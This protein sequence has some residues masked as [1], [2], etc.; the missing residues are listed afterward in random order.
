MRGIGVT[1]V[2][3][4]EVMACGGIVYESDTEGTIWLKVS[5]KC[6]GNRFGWARTIRDVFDLMADCVDLRISSFVL[7]GF[8]QGEKMAKLIGLKKTDETREHNG[9]LY[10]RFA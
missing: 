4:G 8:C 10:Y 9:N 7:N 3:D 5:K 1:G 6:L 2:E